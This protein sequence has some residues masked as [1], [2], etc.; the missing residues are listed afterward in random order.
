[1][2]HGGELFPAEV[3]QM[4]REQFKKKWENYW[5]YYKIHTIVAVLVIIVLA[6]LIKQCADRVEPDM[7]IVLVSNNVMLTDDQTT[8]LDSQLSKLSAD[9]NNDGHKSV[10]V[11]VLYMDKNQDGQMLQA[12][13][14]K[15]MVEEAATD[16]ALYITDDAYYKIL[17]KSKGFFVNLKNVDK[18]APDGTR[19]KIGSLPGL[20]LSGV[21]NYNDL[22]VSIRS[23]GSSFSKTYQDSA[24][25]RNAV[26]I[27]K[28]LMENG[29]LIQE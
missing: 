18:S 8:R 21:S 1:M 19:V 9:V 24:S 25:Y 14:Q 29:G 17:S 6:V 3:L 7:T 4:T 28:K 10:Q 20:K 13:Q 12:L 5:F 26:S 15:L 11:E 16:D 23:F 27:L 22:T 2:L